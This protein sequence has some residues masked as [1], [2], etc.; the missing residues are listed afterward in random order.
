MFSKNQVAILN[1]FRKNLFLKATMLEIMHKLKKKSYQ[2]TY[3]AIKGL[4]KKNMIISNKYGSSAVCELKL[5]PETISSLAFLEEQ[6]ALSKKIP[7]IGKL[8]EF[9]EFVNDILMITGSYAK[10]TSSPRSDIDLIIITRDNAFKKQKLI[11]NMTALFSPPI[12]PIV[13]NDQDYVEM[14][15]EKKENYGKQA[16]KN[17][18]LF[19]NAGKYFELIKEAVERGF[20][21]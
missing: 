18:L 12:H 11:E 16:L 17:R 1:L 6:E 2:R 3:E 7:S 15:L 10:G 21:G 19:R 4:E 5:S 8:L 14:L 13:I 20:R 9:S